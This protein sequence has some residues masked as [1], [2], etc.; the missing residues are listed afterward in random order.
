MA[1]IAI[2]IRLNMKNFLMLIINKKQVPVTKTVNLETI[3]YSFYKI[4]REGTIFTAP[5]QNSFELWNF[6]RGGRFMS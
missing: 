6:L 2:P 1:I 5:V 3:S 4:I